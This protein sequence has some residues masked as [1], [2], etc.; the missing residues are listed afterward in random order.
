VG[1][2]AFVGC[3]V[4]RVKYAGLIAFIIGVFN[5][6]PIAG[7][8]IGAIPSLIMI[9]SQSPK[10]ALYFIVFIVILQQLD[11]NIIGPKCIGQSTNINSFW[12]LASIIIFGK[13]FGFIGMIIGVPLFAVIQDIINK[14]VEYRL[15]DTE[16]TLEEESDEEFVDTLIK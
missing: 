4:L 12:V 3:L 1:I 16:G 7:P 14:V 9:F 6:I 11:G 10:L 2:I 13:L 15:R 5:V 8:F